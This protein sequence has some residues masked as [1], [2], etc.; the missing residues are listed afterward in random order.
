MIEI[1]G[2]IATAAVIGSFFFKDMFKLRI[3]NLSG[4]LLWLTYG[5]LKMDYPLIGV[6]SAVVLV[7]CYWF[8]TNY[9][10]WKS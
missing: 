4:A 3:V 6:N 2:W 1:L 9:K 5:I 10:L 8:I 7:H